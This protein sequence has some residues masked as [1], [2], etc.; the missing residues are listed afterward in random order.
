MTIRSNPTYEGSTVYTCMLNKR[1]GAEADLT[2]SRL[3]TGAANLPLAPGIQ[4]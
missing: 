2:V 4:W 3:E 1:G